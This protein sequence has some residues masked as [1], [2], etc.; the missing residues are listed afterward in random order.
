M[1]V[2]FDTTDEHEIGMCLDT[3]LFQ[4]GEKAFLV[5]AGLSVKDWQRAR[6]TTIKI[7][8]R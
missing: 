4:S 1:S 8:H 3:E 6:R 7:N 5:G 2:R